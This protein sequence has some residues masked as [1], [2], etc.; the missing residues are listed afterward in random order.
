MRVTKDTAEKALNTWLA[1]FKPDT[2]ARYRSIIGR[3]ISLYGN[4]DTE[5][6]DA[7]IEMLN[8]KEYS[9]S[10]KTTT[11]GILTR[12][13]RFIEQTVFA[14]QPAEEVQ[15]ELAVKAETQTEAQPLPESVKAELDRRAQLTREFLEIGARFRGLPVMAIKKAIDTLRAAEEAAQENFKRSQIIDWTASDWW[16]AS[17]S[18]SGL[19]AELQEDRAVIKAFEALLQI[20][21]EGENN[22]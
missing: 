13:A 11:R 7:Y 1:S 22:D 20:V 8:A 3:F 12:F 19:F 9:E 21:D 14:A 15:T 5:N 16:T 18:A 6:I 2:L 4:F 10:H 17:K